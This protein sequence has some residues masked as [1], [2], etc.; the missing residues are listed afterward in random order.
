MPQGWAEC[1]AARTSGIRCV[2]TSV[3]G[4]RAGSPHGERPTRNMQGGPGWGVQPQAD[5]DFDG[6][7][8]VRVGWRGRPAVP[9]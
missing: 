3:Q 6:L 4:A 1:G 9:D 5:R 8:S 7:K 2:V